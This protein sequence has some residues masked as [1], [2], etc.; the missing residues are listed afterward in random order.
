LDGVLVEK[1]RYERI[2][3]KV[4][5]FDN[6]GKDLRWVYCH[7]FQSYAPPDQDW[8]YDETVHYFNHVDFETAQPLAYS[9][10]MATDRDAPQRDKLR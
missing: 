7:L 10:V 8:V 6:S 2:F 9:G 1:K 3:N 4:T 5:N